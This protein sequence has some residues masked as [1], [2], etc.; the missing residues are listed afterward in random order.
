MIE[1]CFCEKAHFYFT[2]PPSQ[3]KFLFFGRVEGIRWIN[4]GGTE[5]KNI[6]NS[7]FCDASASHLSLVLWHV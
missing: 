5:T 2:P 3:S 4:A 7:L 1:V 6:K